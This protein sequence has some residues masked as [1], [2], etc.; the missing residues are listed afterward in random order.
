MAVT[1]RILSLF[2]FSVSIDSTKS[3]DPGLGTSQEDRME[4][5]GMFEIGFLNQVCVI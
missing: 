1:F 2:L 5:E 3:A 4:V